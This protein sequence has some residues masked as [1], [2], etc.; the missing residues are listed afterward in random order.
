MRHPWTEARALHLVRSSVSLEL[1]PGTPM[2]RDEEDL[3]KAGLIDSMG[4]VAIVSALEEAAGIRNFGSVWP[5]SRPQSIHA[6][7]E[8]SCE[9]VGG[10]TIERTPEREESQGSRSVG[11][12]ASIFGWGFALGSLRVGAEEIERQCGV[13]PGTFRDG[14]GIESV[15]RAD[16]VENELVLA[17]RAAESALD[18]AKMA[19]ETVDFV[20][21]TSATFSGF[22][23][24]SAS[25]HSLLL[26]PESCGAI[27]VGGAC[28]GLIHALAT[29][30]ALLADSRHGVALV[31][32]A[33]VNTRRLSS[34][35]I[36]GEFRGLFGDGACAFVLARSGPGNN[37][38]MPTAGDFVWGCSG[39]FASSLRV[40]LPR[41]SE[42]E[43]QFRGEQLAG[44]AVSTLERTLSRIENL[45]G[46]SRSEVSYFAFHE[47]N[48][49]V[50]EILAR[51]AKIPLE[52][53]TL[54]SRTSGNLGSA[55]CGVSLCMALS[56][57]R[58]TSVPPAR[59]LIF[60]AAVGPGLLWG[61]TYFR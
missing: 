16:D 38:E 34:P 49:R 22:P 21:V 57:A 28:V 41:N 4:W 53:V 60:L 39:T 32:A 26:L 51:R 10:G 27:D 19:A 25:L 23:S 56:S 50:V 40:S 52:K 37:S 13:A 2:P 46:K 1:P 18:M 9:V 5:K 30:K 31:V 35:Q 54:I 55:T 33:E 43:V 7:V 14:A 44:T 29:A 42:I 11:V 58:A 47:P 3:V 20:V 6:L 45:S 15:R 8:A 12:A 17:A 48:P 24:L 59:A 36:P 61:G